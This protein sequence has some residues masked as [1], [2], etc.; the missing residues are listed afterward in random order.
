MAPAVANGFAA[1]CFIK[2]DARRLMARRGVV[3]VLVIENAD[4]Y[5]TKSRAS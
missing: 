3:V 1:N 4:R 2:A 5:V